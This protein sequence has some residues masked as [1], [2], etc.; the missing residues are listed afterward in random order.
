MNFALILRKLVDLRL[1]IL[2]IEP[3][4]KSRFLPWNFTTC[5]LSQAAIMSA[6]KRPVSD[7]FGSSQVVVKRQNLGNDI[8][9]ANESGANGALVQAVCTVQNEAIIFVKLG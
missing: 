6:E 2:N 4:R 8:A 9:R 3:E 1:S 7:D 5:L